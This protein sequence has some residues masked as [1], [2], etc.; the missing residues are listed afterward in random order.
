MDLN[1]EYDKEPDVIDVSDWDLDFFSPTVSRDPAF[2]EMIE[3]GCMELK[4]ID[5]WINDN[6]AD[7]VQFLL[8]NGWSIDDESDDDKSFPAHA[9]PDKII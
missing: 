2:F 9:P 1:N 3:E 8:D 5:N 4:K 7:Y 6:Y